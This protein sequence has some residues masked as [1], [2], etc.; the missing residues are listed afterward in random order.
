VNPSHAS[1]STHHAPRSTLSR[2]FTL[3][4]VLV[5]VTL[6]TLVVAGIYSSWTAILKA[7][8][9]GLDVAAAVQRSRIAVR[10]LE[11]SLTCAQSFAQARQYYTFLAENGSE[12]SI[13][14]VARLPKSFPRSGKF[15]DLDVRRVSFSIEPGHGYDSGREL[16]LRQSSL[17]TEMDRDEK[18]HPL[19]LAK[20]VK[21]LGMEFWGKKR[22]GRTEDWLDEWDETNTLPKMVKITL[23]LDPSA[24]STA[25]A[26]EVTRIVQ[27]P[28]VAVDPRYQGGLQR[29]PAPPNIPGAPPGA[30]PPGTQF[31][32]PGT[33]PGQGFVPPNNQQFTPR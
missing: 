14:F 24:H 23:Q 10:T 11:D 22:D 32:P 1:R 13:S 3:L 20:N 25:A 28:A 29:A 6:L 7:S 21:R 12:A 5:A 2:A 31:Q 15:G 9:T 19:V 16:V 33:Q 4:E 26:T 30:I 8:K 27:I 17:L 18:E